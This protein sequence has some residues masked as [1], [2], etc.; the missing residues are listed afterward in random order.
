[1]GIENW[2]KYQELEGKDI[3]KQDFKSNGKKVI[4]TGNEKGLE[5]ER[6]PIPFPVYGEK[7][8]TVM[9]HL[10]KNENETE[11]ACILEIQMVLE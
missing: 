3:L 2:E 10:S 11:L 6:V 8:Y 9:G 4:E 1:M 7:I 5:K